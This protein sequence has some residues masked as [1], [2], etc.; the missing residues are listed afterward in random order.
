MSIV[1]AVIGAIGCAIW[2]VQALLLG[3][4]LS[5]LRL[6]A[7]TDVSRSAPWPRVSVVVPA[8]DEVSSIEAALTSRLADDYPALDIVVIDDR[9]TD[10]TSEAIARVA[11][12]DKRVSCTRVDS[13]PDGWLG[14][15][16]ALSVGVASAGGD[17]L[18]ISDADVHIAPG[19]LRRAIA[20][21]ERETLD[22]L[23][24]V[25]EF[26][27]RSLAVDVAWAVFMR[28]L[29]T[30]VDPGKVRDPRSPVSM[31]SGGFMLVRRAAYERTPGYGHLRMETADDVGL[32]LMMKGSG[33]RCDFANGLGIASI[34]IYDSAGSFFRGIEKN[35]GSL[36]ALRL[37]VVIALIGFAGLVEFSGLIGV[38]S[39]LWWGVAAGTV[40]LVA[41]TASTVAALH[42]NTRRILPALLWPVGWLLVATGIVRAAW[43]LAYRGGVVW[44]DTFYSR[45]QLHEGRRITLPREPD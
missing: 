42:A 5:R 34:E 26:R 45:E 12:R 28:I 29:G 3:G 27:S 10:G 1:L 18:L 9:S 14:K 30:F 38:S 24:L 7:E 17:W 4:H 13:V 31:G 37:P 36:V 43:L 32:G 19:G 39:G 22:F 20:Y 15:V 16:H 33:A 2:I 21:C 23:A 11:G 35:A 25:P 8:R 41:A 40:A 44:R 6:V